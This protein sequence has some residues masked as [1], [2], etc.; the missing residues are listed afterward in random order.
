MAETG[1]EPCPRLAGKRL[2]FPQGRGARGGVS[3]PHLGAGRRQVRGGKTVHARETGP[4][5][6]ALLYHANQDLMTNRLA[7][8]APIV[9]IV[10]ACSSPP[11]PPPPPP[12]TSQPPVGQHPVV[13]A[14]S[15]AGV[16]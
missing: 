11:P 7:L 4:P 1:L 9:L 6:A 3:K 8:L 12:P 16:V 5:H 14:G 10:L 2:A 13:D 15:D